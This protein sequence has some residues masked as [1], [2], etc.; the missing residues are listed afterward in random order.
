MDPITAAI[1]AALPA[2]A[3]DA[4]KQGVKDAYEGLKAVIRR[5]WGESASVSKAVDDLEADPS[6][7]A[8][9]AVLSE[10]IEQSQAAQDHEVTEAH[11]ALVAEL[12]AHGLSRPV[13]NQVTFTMSGGTVQG[14][15]G[16]GSVEIG[17]MTFGS[18]TQR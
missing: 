9:A 12:E 13:S 2:L 14:V 11:K 1:V 16:A 3:P 17:S 8:R 4:L 10:R 18:P 5:K 6:S 15:A 7:K